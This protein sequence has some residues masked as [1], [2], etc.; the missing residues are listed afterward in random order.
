MNRFARVLSEAHDQL[1][2]QEPSRTRVL[3]EMA[4]DLEDSDQSRSLRRSRL[5]AR[6]VEAVRHV[7][8]STPLTSR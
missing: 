7:A 6:R 8:A 2:I 5:R 1:Q 4:S 3:L